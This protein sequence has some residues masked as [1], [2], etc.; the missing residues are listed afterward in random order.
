MTVPIDKDKAYKVIDVIDG[1]TIKILIDGHE[2]TTRLLGIDTPEVVD[3]R[4]PVQCYGKEA[5]HE[6]KSLLT[7][8]SVSIMLNPDYDRT[9]KYGRLLGY[10]Y[11]DGIFV[12]ELLVKEGFAREYTYNDRKPY[13]FQKLFRNDELKAKQANKGL[14]DACLQNK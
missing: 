7:G 14:W 12:N 6:T 10:I 2:I 9:D 5:S 4:K 1:D 3:P 8:K 13:Q 11:L